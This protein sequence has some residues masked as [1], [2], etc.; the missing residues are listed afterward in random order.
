MLTI[1]HV[2]H[3]AV[4]KIGGIGAVLDG[5]ITARPYR[6]AVGR[7]ILV[8]PLF[9]R[10]GAAADRLGPGGTVL[11]SSFDGIGGDAVA[12]GLRDV[13]G[14][15]GVDIVYGRKPMVAPEG[16][17]RVEVEVLLVDVHSIQQAALGLVKF[18][19]F[20]GFGV[21][22]DKFEHVW[23]FEQYVR[24]AGP[25]VDG[26]KALGVK[27][28]CVVVAHEF[29]GMPTALLAMLDKEGDFRGVFH[30]HEAA[31]VRRIVEDHPGQDVAFY[32]LMRRGRRAGKTVTDYFGDQSD[33]FK[34]VLVDAA[35]HCQ[36]VLAVGPEV[37]EELKF[38]SRDFERVDVRL[39]YNGIPARAITSAEAAASKRRL[40]DYCQNLL[41]WRPDYVFTHVARLVRSK[42]LW[43]D[44]MVM[45]HVDEALRREGKTAVLLVLATETGL[46][47]RHEEIVNLERGW[48]WPVAHREGYPDLTHGEAA[49]YAGV[50]AFNARARSSRTVFINQFGFDRVTC[51]ERMQEEMEFWDIRRGSDA[52]FGQSIYEPFGIAQLEALSFGAICVI[53]SVCGCAGFV[54]AAAGERGSLNVIAPDFTKLENDGVSDQALLAMTAAQRERIERHV[55]ERTAA[56]LMER[57]PRTPT[58]KELAIRRGS[59]LA[60]K[61]SWD[62]VARDYFLPGM[63]SALRRGVEVQRV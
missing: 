34:H 9:S 59:E 18:R 24:L 22:S 4:Q 1:A 53:S 33:Y 40:Q 44:L 17:E 29:M 23:D 10:R 28:S 19:L 12:A 57:L 11:F 50:Q 54:E 6:E 27:S 5:L 3:E 51:G 13:C 41:G 14:R 21:A 35:K 25:A 38:L 49:F 2:T 26:L 43:R 20:E 39:A 7:T 48:E 62:V 63:E 46:P 56:V 31:T 60:E 8:G 45:E 30:A 52:E 42:G 32:N 47:R 61:M 15:Y 58:E 16:R 37:V 36:C 55:A